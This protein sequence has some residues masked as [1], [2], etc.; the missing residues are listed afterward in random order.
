MLVFIVGL[1]VLTV[2]AAVRDGVT[3]LTFVSVLV[4]ALLS[5]GVI[6]ALLNPPPND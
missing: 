5:C 4:L 2:A 6:G 3:V 1:A